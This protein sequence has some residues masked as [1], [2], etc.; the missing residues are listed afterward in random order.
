MKRFLCSIIYLILSI[1]L[2]QAVDFDV[3]PSN[4]EGWT[5]ANIVNNGAV[6]FSENQANTGNGSLQFTSTGSTDKA[7]FALVWLDLT[8]TLGTLDSLSYAFY[9][10]SSSTASAHLH[11]VLRLLFYDVA[12]DTYGVLVFEEV[13]Q[14]GGSTPID[15][16]KS[17]DLM[18]KRFWMFISGTGVCETY[19]VTLTDWLAG[20]PTCPFGITPPTLSSDTLIYGV[21]VGIGSGWANSFT[22]YV[23]DVTIGFSGASNTYNFDIDTVVTPSSDEESDENE[24]TVTTTRPVEVTSIIRPDCEQQ[25]GEV[26]SVIRASFSPARP[27]NIV[28]CQI[29]VENQIYRT[30]PGAIGI[31]EIIDQN[32]I[33]AVDIFGLSGATDPVLEFRTFADVCLLGDG[34][35]IV[36]INTFDIIRVPQYLTTWSTSIDGFG[37]SCTRIPQ[38]GLVILIASP[39]VV[40]TPTIPQPLK[41]NNC[42]VTTTDI[43][44]LRSTPEIADNIMR[45]VPF[46]TKLTTSQQTGDWFKVTYQGDT[47]WL[48]GGF[49]LLSSGC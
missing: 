14:V 5:E 10:D 42:T 31:K 19:N 20:T 24:K 6:N 49:L 12:S 30:T 22:G 35:R 28:Y 4:L 15:T 44:N 27:T 7:D 13:Y 11:P 9:R 45:L 2:V 37:Y 48:N 8:I 39:T 47:G 17:Q 38:P 36:Y 43:L 33:Q 3:T 18:D 29:I 40:N 23:D 34:D 41:L 32:I 16:W 26:R 25:F 21:N 46:E 1:S